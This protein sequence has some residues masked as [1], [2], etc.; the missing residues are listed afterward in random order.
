MTPS[1]TVPYGGP[2]TDEK[3]D[4]ELGIGRKWTSAWKDLVS[5]TGNRDVPEVAA[6]ALLCSESC[7]PC[8][9]SILQD[10]SVR[11]ELSCHPLV[12]MPLP[13]GLSLSGV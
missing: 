7:G 11:R 9:S 1:F 5:K 10:R 6:A 4:R 12:C 13:Q 8:G 2:C 3:T